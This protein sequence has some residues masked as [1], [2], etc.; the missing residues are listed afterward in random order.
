V[1]GYVFALLALVVVRPA[2]LAVA[3]LGGGL[4][5]REWIAAA[6]FGPKGFSSVVYGF[7][8]VTS[9]LP[10]AQAL[11]HL[12]AIV[13]AASIMAH[14]STDVLVARWFRKG[15]RATAR[16]AAARA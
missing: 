6:W 2:A 5:R 1:S 7:L 14:S 11:A 9:G 10:R 13:I 15:E 16:E 4:T 3:L 8:V 12:V